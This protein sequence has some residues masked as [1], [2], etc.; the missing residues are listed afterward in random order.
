MKHQNAKR[1]SSLKAVAAFLGF[2]FAAAHGQQDIID[3]IKPVASV[4]LAGQACVGSTV[5]GA[6]A[7]TSNSN[8]NNTAAAAPTAPAAEPV[9]AQE[10]VASFDV[11]A[12]YQL[13]CFAC[14]A[15]GAAGAPKLGDS[16]AWGERME[17][18]MDAVMANVINGV[19]AMPPKGMCMTC[20]DGNLREIVDYML[21]Q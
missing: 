14:H 6:V 18:G 10:V 17:K 7:A 9:A 21:A 1:A 5:G 12:T 3:N 19:N 15:T 16:E 11:E 8:S 2:F 4:C 13:S 20:S